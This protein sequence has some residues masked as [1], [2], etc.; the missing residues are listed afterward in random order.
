MQ[1]IAGVAQSGRAS[2]RFGALG[3]WFESILQHYTMSDS[4]E[5]HMSLGAMSPKGYREASHMDAFF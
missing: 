5:A 2:W 4:I 3:Q 1:L